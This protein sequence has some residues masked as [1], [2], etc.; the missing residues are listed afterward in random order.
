MFNNYMA[1]KITLQALSTLSI[2]TI[3]AL[4]GLPTPCA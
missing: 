4:Q 3:E 1:L 2:V